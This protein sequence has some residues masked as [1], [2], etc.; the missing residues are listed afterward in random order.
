MTAL[1]FLKLYRLALPLPLTFA[2]QPL[3]ALS[4]VGISS[5]RVVVA[6]ANTRVRRTAGRL[7]AAVG[8]RVTTTLGVTSLTS[9]VRVSTTAFRDRLTLRIHKGIYKGMYT[10]ITV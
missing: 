8:H 5:S 9:T 2:P 4:S 7:V 3:P 10:R 1:L 6:R